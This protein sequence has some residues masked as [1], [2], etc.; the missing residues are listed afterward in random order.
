MRHP[1]SKEKIK[2]TAKLLKNNKSPG[3]DGVKT[4]LLKYGQDIIYEEIAHIYYN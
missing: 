4:E 2:Q 1:F 3:K